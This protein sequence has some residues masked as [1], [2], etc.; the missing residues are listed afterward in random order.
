MHRDR[1]RR[2]GVTVRR[3]R[4]AHRPTRPGLHPT[5]GDQ[6]RRLITDRQEYRADLISVWASAGSSTPRRRRE[7]ARGVGHAYYNYVNSACVHVI[8]LD[9]FLIMHD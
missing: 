8:E 2:H 4:R 9:H 5:P 6:W 7:W 1:N 3:P